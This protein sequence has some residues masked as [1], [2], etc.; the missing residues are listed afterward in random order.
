MS[1]P[2][3]GLARPRNIFPTAVA[4]R[5]ETSWNAPTFA[6]ACCPSHALALPVSTEHRLELRSG[7]KGECGGSVGYRGGLLRPDGPPLLVAERP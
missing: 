3:D 7:P 5:A 4:W 6:E 2:N 1:L